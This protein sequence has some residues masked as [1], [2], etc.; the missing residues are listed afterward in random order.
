MNCMDHA[1]L[2]KEKNTNDI[3]TSEKQKRKKNKMQDS[4]PRQKFLKW[5]SQ[6][7]EGSKGDPKLVETRLATSLL[8]TANDRHPPANKP[9]LAR[10]NSPKAVLIPPARAGAA[11]LS[12]VEA[13]R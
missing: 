3:T 9:K 7:I 6:E 4:D 1:R 5:L 10:P 13:S 2:D 11:L 8:P 12:Q